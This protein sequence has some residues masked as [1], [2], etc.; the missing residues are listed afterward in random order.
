MIYT[1]PMVLFV[2]STVCRF[3][4]MRARLSRS[5]VPTALVSRPHYGP[6]RL[7][8]QWIKGR[9]SYAGEDITNVEASAIVRRRLIHVPEGRRIFAPLTV[10]ENLEMGLLPAATGEGIEEAWT[11]YSVCSRG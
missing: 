6:F 7:S 4:S 8:C 1:S 9:I 3:T 5:S 2:L 10:R 11:M